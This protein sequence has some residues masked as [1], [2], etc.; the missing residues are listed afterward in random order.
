[1]RSSEGITD[2]RLC[3]L[4]RGIKMVAAEMEKS[5]IFVMILNR[6]E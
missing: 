2:S 6:Q 3:H 4:L 5:T 1:M